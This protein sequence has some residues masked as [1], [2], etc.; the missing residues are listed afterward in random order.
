MIRG[1]LIALNLV[2]ATTIDVGPALAQTAMRPGQ[3]TT[4][5]AP[6]GTGVIRGRITA[7][8]TGKPLRRAADDPRA[9]CQ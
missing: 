9:P 7:G 1:F 4:R 8:D 6:K 5:D 3:P 2:C